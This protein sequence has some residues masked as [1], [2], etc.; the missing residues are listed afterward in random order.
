LLASRVGIDDPRK[1]PNVGYIPLRGPMEDS[2]EALDKS[3]LILST[4]IPATE[5]ITHMQ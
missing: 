5:Q 3:V 2:N 1:D 4:Y